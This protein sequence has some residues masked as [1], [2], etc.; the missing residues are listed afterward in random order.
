MTQAIRPVYRAGS[1]KDT[2]GQ[3]QG[4]KVNQVVRL[5]A[6]P[7]YAVGAV[8]VKAG[9]NAD[10]L[11]VTFMRIKGNQLDPKDAY[12]SQWVGDPRPGGRTLLGGDGRPVV[13]IFG[14]KSKENTSG[15]GLI[16]DPKA[17]PADVARTDPARPPVGDQPAPRPT[18]TAG[19]TLPRTT[20]SPS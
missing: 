7:G 4:T 19:P 6:K 13:G 18:P 16:F 20:S 9:G 12:E 17:A 3:Q 15:L 10:G 11:S 5:V 1:N 14:T 8:N 2:L